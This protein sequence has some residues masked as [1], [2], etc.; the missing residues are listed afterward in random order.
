MMVA[1]ITELQFFH[2]AGFLSIDNWFRYTVYHCRNKLPKP[3]TVWWIWILAVKFYFVHQIAW[4]LW[5]DYRRLQLKEKLWIQRRPE[6]GRQGRRRFPKWAAGSLLVWFYCLF[7]LGYWHFTHI[8]FRSYV[9]QVGMILNHNSCYHLSL[10]F[11]NCM[12]M[13]SPLKLFSDKEQYKSI[14]LELFCD[15]FK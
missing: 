10:I 1:P 15:H 13:W 6:S 9:D 4:L 8:T 3:L 14:W 5:H 12:A 2:S 11:V 7:T